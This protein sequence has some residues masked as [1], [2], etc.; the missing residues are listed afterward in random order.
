VMVDV[1]LLEALADWGPQSA[2]SD[3]TGPGCDK[4]LQAESHIVVAGFVGAGGRKV[5]VVAE[6]RLVA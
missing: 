6:G 2:S 3:S 4:L 1:G 5:V